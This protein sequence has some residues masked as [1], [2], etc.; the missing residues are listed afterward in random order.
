MPATTTS[1][2]VHRL[3]LP[4]AGRTVG[5][6]ERRDFMK[7][8]RSPWATR[9]QF[10]TRKCR[11]SPRAQSSYTED[12][13]TPRRLATSQTLNKLRDVSS[14]PGSK[15]AAKLCEKAAFCCKGLDSAGSRS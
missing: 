9:M 6:P 7:S 11:S 12:L 14:E 4:S 5:R 13:D 15:W 3:H 8:R 10:M 1:T 2:N